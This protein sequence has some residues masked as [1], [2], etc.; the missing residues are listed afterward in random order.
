VG[1]D[2]ADPVHEARE[3]LLAETKAIDGVLPEPAASVRI[4]SFT[5]Q[6]CELQVFFWVDTERGP[7]LSQVRSAVMAACLG[8]LRGEGFTLSSD[9][10]TAVSVSQAD[11]RQA[12]ARPPTSPR[13]PSS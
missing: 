5:P 7:G 3:L 4:S 8:A 1:L 13:G 9:V 11:A 6:Y 10:S 2:Y 12:G